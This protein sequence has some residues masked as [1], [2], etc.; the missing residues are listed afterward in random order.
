M[1]KSKL[2][3][4]AVAAFAAISTGCATKSSIESKMVSA[5]NNV[6]IVIEAPR[7]RETPPSSRMTAAYMEIENTNDYPV[8]VF[9]GHSDKHSVVE[10]HDVVMEGNMHRM[11]KQEFIRIDANS[12]LIMKPGSFHVML[13]NPTSDTNLGVGDNVGLTLYFQHLDTKDVY[14]KE[15]TAPVVKVETEMGNMMHHH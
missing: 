11:V 8:H 14:K 5:T 9:A 2:L 7:V 6:G 4:A 13:I 1:N 15:L 10:M 3:V 12:T